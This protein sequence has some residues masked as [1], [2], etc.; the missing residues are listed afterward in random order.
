[1]SLRWAIS[2]G[3]LFDVLLPALLACAIICSTLVL[4]DARRRRLPFHSIIA[5]T[6]GTLALPCTVLPLYLLTRLW[7]RRA[8]PSDDVPEPTPAHAD[9]AA[10]DIQ[11]DDAPPVRPRAFLSRH[12]PTIVYALLTTTLG[13]LFF[14]HYY[15]G[16]DGHLARASNA[17]L[18]EQ[19]A[20]AAN[21]YRAA[22]RL[23]DDPHTHKHLGLEL[24]A[25]NQWADALAE[26]RTAERGGEPDA[27]LP[28]HIANT[29]T[30]LDQRAEAADEYRRFLTGDL[31]TQAMPDARCQQAQARLRPEQNEATR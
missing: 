13:A 22:L 30:A 11:P 8:Q 18:Y 12:A 10:T 1:M 28:Y 4:A 7:P 20:R 9:D 14:Q 31:C 24:A 5:W 15:F 29:L 23:A 17:K 26:L 27:A 6:L 3:Q 19:H 16:L 25:S 21:E 2:A